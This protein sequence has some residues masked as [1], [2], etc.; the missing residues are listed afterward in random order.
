MALPYNVT[1]SID[2]L[3][4]IALATT[5]GDITEVINDGGEKLLPEL[6]KRGRIFMVNDA[7]YASYDILHADGG[8]DVV[9]YKVDATNGGV[10]A[11][12]T[13]D[14]VA[15]EILSSARFDILTSSRNIS[16]GQDMPAGNR[17]PFLVTL[18]RSSGIGIFQ[19]EECL[20]VRGEETSSGTPDAH[21]PREGDADST[22]FPM[23]LLG[24]VSSGTAESGVAGSIDKSA[25][26]FA[27]VTGITAWNPQNVAASNATMTGTLLEKEIQSHKFKLTF[28][29]METPDTL[30]VG[31]LIF[32]ALL[33]EMRGRMR[34]AGVAS[35]AGFDGDSFPFA[36]MTVI[37]HRM[38]DDKSI[39]YDLP[40]GATACLPMYFLNLKSL[41]MNIV[42]Q[43]QTIGEGFGFLN[44]PI[45]GVHPHPLKTNLFQR[46]SW[47]RSYAL[48]HGRRSFGFMHG[49]VNVTV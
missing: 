7:E 38:L 39:F 34:T 32:E 10:P 45:P 4:S 40:A 18:V 49:I 12:H 1:E 29:P 37:R 44:S 16:W 9:D 22:T 3:F 15:K 8:G 17:L 30:L 36:G 47:K 24:L 2:T 31:T 19:R 13:L 35:D 27:G 41:R 11:G 6:A 21:A 46:V 28:N 20:L 26:T 33:T 48:D 14:N 23:S 5:S 43:G 25:E 42:A